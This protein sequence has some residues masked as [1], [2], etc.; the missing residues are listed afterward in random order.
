MDQYVIYERPID[1]PSYFVVRK[2]IIGR[3]TVLM[4]DP[5]FKLAKTLEEARAAVPNKM[6]RIARHPDDDSVIVEVWI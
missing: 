4:V 1:Y 3:G 2:V 5:P 6:Q